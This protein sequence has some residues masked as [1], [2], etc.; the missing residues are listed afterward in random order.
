MALVLN[1]SS[2]TGLASSGGF[3]SRQTGEV[4]QVVQ[5]FFT[6]SFTTSSNSMTD[7][8][9]MSVTITP[10]SS[11]SKILLLTS[12][13]TSKSTSG[14]GTAFQWVRNGTAVGIGTL[15]TTGP[16]YSFGYTQYGGNSI[17]NVNFSYLDSPATTSAITYKLQVRVE[18]SGGTFALNNNPSYLNVSTDVY[19]GGY[20]STLTAME[21][22]A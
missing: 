10:T 2:I 5:T 8:T 20:T 1:S 22:A 7:A 21:I 12:M 11:S 19:H 16:N 18:G 3:S 14:S 15:G 6:T 4:L 17:N 13:S 9:G